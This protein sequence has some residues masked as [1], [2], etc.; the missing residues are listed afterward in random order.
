MYEAEAIVNSKL[1]FHQI[2]TDSKNYLSKNYFTTQKTSSAKTGTLVH[3][4]RIKPRE[5]LS[6]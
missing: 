3:N 5:G 6:Y 4:Y 2:L 1:T